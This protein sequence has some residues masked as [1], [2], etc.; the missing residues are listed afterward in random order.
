[1]KKLLAAT[2]LLGLAIV[3]TE[4]LT[5]AA[6]DDKPKFTI[7]QVMKRAMKGGLCK[8]VASGKA[9][10]AEKKELLELFQAMAK[11]KPPKGDA[12]SWKD[13]TEALV[14]AANANVKGEDGAGPKLGKAANC[15]SCHSKHKGS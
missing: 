11:Q 12:D 13:K 1:M 10:D 8:K 5:R 7:K 6:D 15:K 14:A 9:D 3:T 4:T 2:L